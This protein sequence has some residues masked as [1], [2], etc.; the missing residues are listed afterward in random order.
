MFPYKVVGCMIS[1]SRLSFVETPTMV[2]SF[3]TS[4]KKR[5]EMTDWASTGLLLSQKGVLLGR[6]ACRCGLIPP[7]MYSTIPD[8]THWECL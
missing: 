8:Y 4:K 3:I 2:S 1:S 6:R 5:D 7:G